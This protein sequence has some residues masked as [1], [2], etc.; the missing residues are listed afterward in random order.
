M[1]TENKHK[2]NLSEK[3]YIFECYFAFGMQIGTIAK[4]LK[5]SY[6]K[7]SRALDD[8]FFKLSDESTKTITLK[9]KV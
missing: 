1:E 8:G 2:L 3:A 5:F 9:S 6:T 4:Q 7:V